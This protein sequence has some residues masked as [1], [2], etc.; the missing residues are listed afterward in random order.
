M[1]VAAAA[2]SVMVSFMTALALTVFVVM[3]AAVAVIVPAVAVLGR[4]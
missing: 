3:A 2:F 4:F 1:V